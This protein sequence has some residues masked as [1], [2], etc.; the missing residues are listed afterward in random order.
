MLHVVLILQ[1]SD[2]VGGT[3]D[4]KGIRPVTRFCHNNSQKFIFGYWSNSRKTGRL[5]KEKRKFVYCYMLFVAAS[6][7]RIIRDCSECFIRVGRVIVGS[8][9]VS[10]FVVSH[11]MSHHAVGSASRQAAAAEDGME[12]GRRTR[13]GQLRPYQSTHPWH[14]ERSKRYWRCWLKCNIKKLLHTSDS[15]YASLWYTL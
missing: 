7:S 14:E 1:C 13:E 8:N 10:H 11:R 4:C 9:G 12:G 15:S 6:R 3:I 2:T 5:N